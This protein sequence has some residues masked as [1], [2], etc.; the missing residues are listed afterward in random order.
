MRLC[1]RGQDAAKLEVCLFGFRVEVSR[2]LVDTCFSTRDG[3]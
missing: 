3:I 2:F 1:A